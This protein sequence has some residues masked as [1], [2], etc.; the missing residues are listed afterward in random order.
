VVPPILVVVL[1]IAGP[2]LA[3]LAMLSATEGAGPMHAE[4]HDR[5][6]EHRAGVVFTER[7]VA[8]VFGLLA[9]AILIGSLVYL[10]EAKP[11]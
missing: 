3:A 8:C 1:A 2:L 10:W 6:R 11:F 7:S 9:A 4:R 5:R